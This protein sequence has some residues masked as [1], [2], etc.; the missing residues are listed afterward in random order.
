MKKS[1]ICINASN[2][3]NGGGVQV[4][5]SF[6]D[7]LSRLEFGNLELS[8]FASEEVD[9][10][11]RQISTDTTVFKSYKFFN[12]YGLSSL[13][14]KNSRLFSQF[15]LVFTVFGPDYFALS[16]GIRITG[17]AQPWII[18]PENEVFRCL[19]L[20]DKVKIRLKFFVQGLFFRR[21][22]KLVVELEHV[23]QGL[24]DKKLASAENVYVVQNCL[25][26]LYFQPERWAPISVQRDPKKFSIGFVG[27]DYPHKNTKILPEIKRILFSRYGLDVDFYVTF[28]PSEWNSKSADFKSV[29]RNV[30]ALG[31]AECP[32]FYQSMDAVIFPSLL[33]CFSATPLEAMVMNKPLFASD[34]GFVRDVC[35]DFAWYFDPVNPATAAQVVSSYIVNHFSGDHER[36][37]AARAHAVGFPSARQRA[38]G[39]LEI[40]NHSLVK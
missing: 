39:Y 24:I 2:L 33:E 35:A 29:I 20:F 1:S 25:S 26:S 3:H 30:G 32:Y 16:K 37:S 19:S 34:R 38:L 9:G 31:V 21:S 18:Y 10:N 22:A 5:A 4:A 23:R 11:L 27:R 12:T 28:N 15:D 14:P 17:F 13:L 40:I 36:L 8:V 7:E 6:I